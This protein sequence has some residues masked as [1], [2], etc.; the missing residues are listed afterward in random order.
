MPAQASAHR[1]RGQALASREALRE[2]EHPLR[3]A[4]KTKKFSA[5]SASLLLALSVSAGAAA[6]DREKARADLDQ[7]L[8]TSLP[9]ATLPIVRQHSYKMLGRVR[10]FLIWIS[11]DDVGSGFINWRALGDNVGYDLLI[12]SDPLRAPNR[13]NKWGFLA[14]ETS[15]GEGTVVGAMSKDNENGLRDVNTGLAKRTQ[16][17]PFDTIQGRITTDRAFARVNTLQVPSSLTY[18]DAAIL[19][20][21]TLREDS[22][23]VREVVRP[24]A[25]RA[26]FLTSVAEVIR[27]NVAS[28]SSGQRIAPQ[29]LPYIYGDRLYELR[30][31]DAVPLARFERDGRTYEH[32]I[33]GRFETGRAGHAGTRFELVY[34]TSG[35]F[36]EIP[37]LI[38]YQPKWWLQVELTIQT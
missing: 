9:G 27:N 7:R 14:E 32:V 37:I 28:F 10:P 26:G 19:L 2:R 1:P 29:T 23:P 36:A 25:A 12:G 35:P 3:E 24:G 33:R 4:S 22:A 20:A 13:L 38:S 5:K 11:R 6:D 21:D 34:G 18:K 30:L 15:R 17:R 16:A 8:P 31:L